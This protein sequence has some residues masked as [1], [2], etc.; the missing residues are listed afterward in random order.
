MKKI[1]FL[2]SELLLSVSIFSMSTLCYANMTVYPMESGL[3]SNGTAQVRVLSKSNETQ[4]IKIVTKQILRAATPKEYEVLAQP[5]LQDSLVVTPEKFGLAAGSQR[6]IRLISLI[7]PEKETVWRV[8]FE[9]VKSIENEEHDPNTVGSTIGINLVWGVLVHVPPRIPVIALSLNSATGE[10]TNNG[11]QRVV[12]KQIG[13]CSSVQQC[14]WEDHAAN[15]YPDESFYFSALKLVGNKHD[16]ELKIRYVDWIK[17]STA[18][19]II[20]K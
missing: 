11:T 20:R 12:I 19:Y 18:E 1:Y 15:I 10:V 7:L 2:A 13:F 9:G 3:D 17:K 16:A 4:Y 14:R 8:Y 5:G 6:I